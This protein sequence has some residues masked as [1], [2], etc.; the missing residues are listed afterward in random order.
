MN[1]TDFTVTEISEGGC[2]VLCDD[3]GESTQF[4]S[5]PEVTFSFHDKTVVKSAATFIRIADDEVVLKL[6]PPIPLPVII[7]EQHWVIRKF[8]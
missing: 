3:I 6:L 2:R 5:G 1:G 7:A 8:P 4:N